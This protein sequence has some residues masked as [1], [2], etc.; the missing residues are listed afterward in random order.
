MS[1]V[2]I[3]INTDNAA[4]CDSTGE[5]VAR[6]LSDLATDIEVHGLPERKNLM[7]YNGN[8]VGMF[9]FHPDS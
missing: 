7:D 5:E 4:F 6:I 9:K 2:T 1:R 8:S 3:E